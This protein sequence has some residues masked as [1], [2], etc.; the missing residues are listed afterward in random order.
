[1]LAHLSPTFFVFSAHKMLGTNGLGC[2]FIEKNFTDKMAPFLGGGSMISDVEKEYSSYLD[3]PYLYEGGTIDYPA[4]V[5]FSESIKY[6]SNIGIKNI[7]EYENNLTKKLF[8]ILD[9]FPEIEVYG[10]KNLHNKGGVVSL[11][12]KGVH[13]H[14][15]NTILDANAILVRSGHHCAQLLMKKFNIPGT[16]RVSFYLY[17]THHEIEKLAF[18]IEKA[19][20][21]FKRKV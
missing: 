12:L 9:A 7:E 8:E 20:T 2:L 18:A 21:L 10:T 19:I 16:V 6:I 11:N 5:A 1:N 13:P 3:I 17:N 15:L 4:V 14:D